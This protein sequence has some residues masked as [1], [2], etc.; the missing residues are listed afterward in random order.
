MLAEAQ[1]IRINHEYITGTLAKEI[2][3]YIFRYEDLVLDPAP[4]LKECFKLLLDVNSI[5]GTV[6]DKRIDTIAR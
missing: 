5:E 4:I 1:N 6:V 3:I 2:P